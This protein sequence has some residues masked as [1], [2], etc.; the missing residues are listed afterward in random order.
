MGPDIAHLQKGCQ[1]EEEEQ[2]E[3]HRTGI[4]R[5]KTIHR[6]CI[7]YYLT[8]ASIN[9]ATMIKIPSEQPKSLML[10]ERGARPVL[11]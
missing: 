6:P 2:S 5:L 7:V 8:R 11:D 1:E 9:W 3:G 4:F 10:L